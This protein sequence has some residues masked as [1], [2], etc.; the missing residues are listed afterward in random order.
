[1]TEYGEG[2][3]ERLNM[4]KYMGISGILGCSSVFVTD[5]FSDGLHNYGVFQFICVVLAVFSASA[6]FI[7]GKYAHTQYDKAADSTGLPEGS[8]WSLTK[9]IFRNKNFLTFVSMSFM[10]EFHI[11]Y[12]MSFAKIF[13]E[14][15]ISEEEMSNSVRAV[16][17]G[18]LM[19][20][21]QVSRQGIDQ[22]KALMSLIHFACIEVAPP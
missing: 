19:V 1:M 5:Y 14:Q 11:T 2:D 18:A 10:Q 8:Y 15:M 22:T 13:T 12:V 7:T 17:L 3:E 21:A 9:D 4:V 20:L 16:L 6:F